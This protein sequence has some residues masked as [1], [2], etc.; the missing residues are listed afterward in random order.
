M[1]F[2]MCVVMLVEF[3]EYALKPLAAVPPADDEGGTE[4]QQHS[5]DR[6][7]GGEV[8]GVKRSALVVRNGPYVVSADACPVVCRYGVLGMR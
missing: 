2:G 3:A 1:L 6:D 8:V 4:D 5:A 7:D